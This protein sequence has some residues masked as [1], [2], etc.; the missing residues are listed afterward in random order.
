M[1][2]IVLGCVLLLGL[3]MGGAG[4]RAVGRFARR[5]WRPG[6]GVLALAAFVAAAVLGVMEKFPAAIVFG[7]IGLSLTLSTRR[8]RRTGPTGER[9]PPAVRDMGVEAAASILGVAP[10]ASDEEVQAAY[11]RLIRRVHPDAGGAAGLAAQLN[12]ARDV[13]TRR[14]N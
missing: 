10:D 4:M 7:L 8:T 2:F 1:T 13:M 6:A 14:K 3:L 11:L 9:G 12:A 5:S